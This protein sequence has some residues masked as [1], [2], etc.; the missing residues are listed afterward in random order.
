MPALILRAVPANGAVAALVP[1]LVRAA[2]LA[3]PA[4]AQREPADRELQR[5]IESAGGE[6]VA[7]A[8]NLEDYLRRFPDSPRRTQ[9]YRALTEVCLQ[10]N[11][12]PRAL[13]FAER[14]IALEPE[15]SA[16][17]LLASELLE[18]QGDER[19]LTR[20]SGYL[21]RILDRVEKEKAEASDPAMISEWAEGRAKLLTAVYLTRARLDVTRRRYDEAEADLNAAAAFGLTAEGRERMGEIAE[22]RGNYVEAIDHYIA[23]F[24]M[25][26]TVG[27]GVDR[28]ALRRRLENVWRLRFGNDAGLEEK[29]YDEFKRMTALPPPAQRAAANAGLT[30]PF[31]F[32]L[33]VPQ[34]GELAMADYRRKLL[35]LHFWATW[36]SPCR[37]LEPLLE[38]VAARFRD[39]KDVA[40]LAL[41]VD[42]DEQ[43][44]REYLQR[45]RGRMAVA[46]ADGLERL[47]QV[48]G[49]PTVLI[50]NASGRVVHRRPGFVRERFVEELASAIERHLSR[51]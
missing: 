14:Y 43:A 29:L 49:V 3:I 46:Y 32:R 51:P 37:E 38:Q 21:T 13:E 8:R 22:L 47:F 6:R 1:L 30:D 15:D 23:A 26:D 40:F 24:L 20:A 10:L 27:R 28:V 34:G 39:H 19:S 11:D 25:L 41:S 7:L 18:E 4:A 33:Q 42:T 17:M 50:V 35:V 36:C 12:R 48:P 16:M 5:A 45:R 44:V 31:S 2:L 9:V